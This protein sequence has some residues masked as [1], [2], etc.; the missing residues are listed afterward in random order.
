MKKDLLITA[1][2]TSISEVLETMFFCP[3]EFEPSADSEASLL[4]TPMSARIAF[5]GPLAGVMRLKLSRGLALSLT[6]DFLGVDPE[7]VDDLQ[8]AEMVKEMLN[9]FAG[10]TFSRFDAGAVFDLGI[11]AMAGDDSPPP[12]TPEENCL[13]VTGQTL[14]GPLEC[15]LIVERNAWNC[16]EISAS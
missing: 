1:M 11:P 8:I 6:A 16:T 14:H 13:V 5:T 10:N 12:A 3:L 4:D 2:K 9:M 7:A 15:E